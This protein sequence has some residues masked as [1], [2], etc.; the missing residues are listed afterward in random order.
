MYD[1]LQKGE[2]HDSQGTE[3]FS[4]GSAGDFEEGAITFPIYQQVT[5][6]HVLV[7]EAEIAGALR[8]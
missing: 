4:D 8:T 2:I 5:D 3:T 1:C 6:R 7:N